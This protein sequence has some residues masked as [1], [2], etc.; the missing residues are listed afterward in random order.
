VFFIKPLCAAVYIIKI[1]VKLIEIRVF[2]KNPK[3]PQDVSEI[4]IPGKKVRFSGFQDDAKIQPISENPGK[5][6]RENR[7]FSEK[8]SRKSENP[9]NSKSGNFGKKCQNVDFG[10]FNPRLQ[11]VLKRTF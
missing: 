10:K 4:Q 3:I 8:I 11:S 5:N 7:T 1:S 9:E 2:E 6:F